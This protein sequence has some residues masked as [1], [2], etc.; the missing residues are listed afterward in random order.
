MIIGRDVMKDLGIDLSFST[1]TIDWE[2]RA[3]PF[4]SVED[5]TA[6]HKSH[7]IPD[8]GMIDKAAER[9][10]KILDAKYEPADLEEIAKE[11]MRLEKDEQQMLLNLLKEHESLFDGTLGHWK[12]EDL[13]IELLPGAKPYHARSCPAPKVHEAS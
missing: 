8:P 11:A 3:L 9:L 12:H 5:L 6:F 4:R 13:E 7:Y 10:K 2:G 1:E